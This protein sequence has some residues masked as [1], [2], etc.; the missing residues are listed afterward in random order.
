MK[1]LLFDVDDTLLDFKLA[2]KKALHALFEEEMYH[3]H[4]KSSQHTTELIKDYGVHLK[5]EK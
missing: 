4:L 5:K 3:L 1:T 2:E